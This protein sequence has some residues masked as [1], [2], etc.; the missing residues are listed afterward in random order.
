MTWRVGL[1]GIGTFAQEAYLPALR[2]ANGIEVTLLCGR[3]R[4]RVEAV[5]RALALD[6]RVRGS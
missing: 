2:A 4:E 6:A 3:S 5:N 1:V